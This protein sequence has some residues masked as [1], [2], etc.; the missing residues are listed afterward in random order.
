MTI[1]LQGETT[2]RGQLQ[3]EW[4]RWRQQKRKYLDR[5]KWWESCVKRKIFYIFIKEGNERSWADAMNAHFYYTCI[6]DILQ[7]PN[8][9]RDKAA[10]LNHL[11]A[12]IVRLFCESLC[13]PC[14]AGGR[15][16][17]WA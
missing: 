10:I 7:D 17:A 1:K 15:T 6:Y 13:Q 4:S 14:N 11:K 3:Q 8:Q 9:H 2:F 12:K 5:V 16:E